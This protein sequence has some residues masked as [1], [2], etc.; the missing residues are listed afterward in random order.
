MKTREITEDIE[1]RGRV[2]SRFWWSA[3]PTAQWWVSYFDPKFP[4]DWYIAINAYKR[5]I[6]PPAASIE[7][8]AYCNPKNGFIHLYAKTPDKRRHLDIISMRLEI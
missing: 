6:S 5:D 8:V 3:H 1:T 4:M 7:I 2:V